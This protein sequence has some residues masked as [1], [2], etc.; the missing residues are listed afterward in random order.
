MNSNFFITQFLIKLKM[1]ILVNSNASA[2]AVT[3]NLSHSNRVFRSR[4]EKLSSGN[5]INGSG[6][7]KGELALS[8]KL[9][10]VGNRTSATIRNIQNPISHSKAQNCA[11]RMARKIFDEIPELGVIADT[12]SKNGTEQNKVTNALDYLEQNFIETEVFHSR[13]FDTYMAHESTKFVLDKVL[14]Q[15]GAAMINYANQFTN[16]DLQLLE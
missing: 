8:N 10:S 16:I 6:Y 9:R 1:S 12:H 7:E 2:T 15:A 11:N 3:Y 4:L 14:V 5:S 13:T